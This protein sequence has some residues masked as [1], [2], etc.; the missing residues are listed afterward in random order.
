MKRAARVTL[1]LLVCA[2]FAMAEGAEGGE[3]GLA[4]WKWANFVVLALG[5]GYLMAKGLPPL[6]AS[7]TKAILKDMVESKQIHQDADRRAADVERRLA[8][9]DGEI[10][11]LKHESQQETD[12]EADRLAKHTAAEIARIQAQAER[13]ISDAGKT[14]QKELRRYAAGLAV[15]LAARKIS[16]RMTPAAQERL[17][18]GFVRELK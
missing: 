4:V 12:E 13:E 15:D 8:A 14:A 3:D 17:V 11:A 6:F 5:L 18:R 9:I 7:R 2:A 10:A 16:S 1:L